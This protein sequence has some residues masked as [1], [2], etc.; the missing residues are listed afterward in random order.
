MANTAQPDSAGPFRFDRPLP[1]D[2]YAWW[3]VDALSDDGQHGLTIIAMLG[4]VFSPYYA[5]ARRRGPTDPLQHCALN[6][7]LYGASGRRWAMTERDA[8]ALTRSSTGLRI[9]PSQLQWDGTR[10]VI[11]IDER[12][13]PL[14]RALRGQVTLE[15][16]AFCDSPALAL[17]AGQL[18][19]WQP[20]APVARVD[21]RMQHPGLTWNGSAYLDSNFG[22]RP[23]EQDFRGW[24]WARAT[25]D[26]TTTVTYDVSPLAGPERSIALQFEAS[27]KSRSFEPPPRAS[28]P[29]TGWG[30][31]RSTR[32]DPGSAPAVIETLEDGPFYA[33]SLIDTRHAG[34]PLREV[35]E[36]LSLQRFASRWVQVLLPVRMPRRRS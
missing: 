35:H 33:R 12:T 5:W 32:C 9:G 2:G 31:E 29:R 22:S 14:P 7:A 11:D 30:I 26:G 24:T 23:L 16:P 28:L 20:L 6:V 10:L 4:T 36:S 25:R 18:H 13:A 17:D 8:R 3:Y 27:G 19:S 21:V 1:T 34:Q 15:V